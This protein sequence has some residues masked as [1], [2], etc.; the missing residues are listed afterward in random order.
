M[1]EIRPIR[2]PPSPSERAGA[3]KPAG[4]RQQHERQKQKKRNRRKEHPNPDDPDLEHQSPVD[5]KKGDD[6]K[7]EPGQIIDLQ[8]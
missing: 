1:D 7:S 6:D 2:T 4:D 3:V 8:A 5:E